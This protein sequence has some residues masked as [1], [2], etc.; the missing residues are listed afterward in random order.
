MI[1]VLAYT[2][3]ALIGVSLGLIGGGGSIITVPVLVYLFGIEPL[4]ATAYSLFIVG[5]TSLVG[6]IPKFREGL[7]NLRAAIIFGAPSIIAVFL[8]RTIFVPKIPPVLGQIGG[9][10]ITNNLVIMVV[11]SLL[12]VFAAVSM[13]R[14]KTPSDYTTHRNGFQMYFLLLAE[15]TVVGII[16][17][18]VGAGGGF[19]I[20]PALVLL[21]RLPMKEAI[22]TS[23]C[24]IAAKSLL[25]FTGDVMNIP[26]NWGLALSVTLVAVVGIF[27]GNILNRHIK[28]QKL[29][30]IFAWFVLLMGLYI[31]AK[32]LL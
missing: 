31:L 15:G 6:V 5:V 30:I 3:A 10:T 19:L 11:F 9:I 17:G 1:L 24:I 7:V 23:L 25:G 21:A 4:M 26:I 8:T 20:I 2:A 22:G 12:M 29:K 28:A 14:D 13:I 16:T 18:F 32:E 27:V